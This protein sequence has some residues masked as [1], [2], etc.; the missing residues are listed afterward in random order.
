MKNLEQQIKELNENLAKQ[1]PKEVLDVF[2]KSIEELKAQQLEEKSTRTGSN[3]PAFSLLN[4]QNET[5][6]LKELLKKGE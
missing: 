6:H 4:T 5:V 1:L 2:G 3:F